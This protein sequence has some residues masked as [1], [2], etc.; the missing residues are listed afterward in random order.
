LH[1]IPHPLFEENPERREQCEKT[2]HD[3]SGPTGAKLIRGRGRGFHPP[4]LWSRDFASA[5]LG[6]AQRSGQQYRRYID[7]AMCPQNYPF[8]GCDFY[9]AS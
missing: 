7:V 9:R 2:V 1:G 3:A 4:F 6:L 8:I 5:L